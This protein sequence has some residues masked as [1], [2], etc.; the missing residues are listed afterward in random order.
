[1]ANQRPLLHTSFGPFMK[2]VIDRA[3]SS[4]QLTG[5]A[6]S[7]QNWRYTGA[8]RLSVRAGTRQVL[9][10]KDD[11]GSPATVTDVCAGVYF[12]D[13]ALIVAHSTITNKAY[14]YRLNATLDTW[15]DAAG[16]THNNNTPQPIGVLWTAIPT[17]PEVTIAEGL[18]VAYIAHTAALDGSALAFPTKMYTD[19]TW[20]TATLSVDLQ[21][22][23]GAVPIYFRGVISFQQH[24]WGWS[25]GAGAS[26]STA[27]RPELAR[28]SEP[29][30]AT[31]PSL[32]QVSDSFT[33]GNR[34]RSL[35]EGIVGGFVAGESLFL[36][37]PYQ[38]SQIT[39]YGRDTWFKQPLDNSYG[40]V[41]HKCGT[42]AGSTLYYWSP[43]GP[44]RIVPATLPEPEPLF[45]RVQNIVEQVINPQNVVA[46]FD[47]A[48]DTVI[49]AF[50]TGSGVRTWAGYDV[51]RDVWLGPNNDFGATFR[52]LFTVAPI[53][54]ATAA[55][56]L[57]PTAAPSSPSTTAVGATTAQ[58]NWVAGD[59]TSPSQVEYRQQG[60]STWT[61]FATVS[62]GVQSCVLTGLTSNVAY[63]WRV[64]HVKDSI[65]SAY[66]GPS[67][68]TQFTTQ[69]SGGALNPPTSPGVMA[70]DDAGNQPLT[71]AD[72]ANCVVSWSNSGE[73]GAD[74]IVEMDTNGGGYFQQADCAPGVGSVTIVVDFSGTY[75]FR[76]KH[77][78]SG[79]ADS[80]YTT[81]V[82]VT[83]D[84][85]S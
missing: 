43:R 4:Q 71:F 76:M 34:V 83:V 33:L 25:F 2:G 13:G 65:A 81:P 22:G 60:G 32:F 20:T 62:A 61:V 47:I 69:P 49:F 51:R 18:G 37:A 16:A 56:T 50:D 73:S 39:G 78:R 29:N 79:Y 7:L 23:N 36:G 48:T 74:T 46:G 40:F 70:Q 44:I 72:H 75:S 38:V 64:A 30:F 14:L 63:E 19:A 67:V 57:G 35:R 54:A 31:S 3:Q 77:T 42:V 55:P 84:I 9:T 66:A 11:Q 6:R 41:N 10:L 82:S 53:Y 28:F 68:D 5:V 1:M 15:T 8:N 27:F 58:T 26:A 85:T 21:D 59:P 80:D 12:A 17:C 52:T 45:D 24:L